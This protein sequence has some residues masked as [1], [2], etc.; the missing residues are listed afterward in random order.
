MPIKFFLTLTLSLCL[1]SMV[2]AQKTSIRGA[3]HLSPSGKL[4]TVF[5]RFG[6]KYA[7]GQIAIDDGLRKTTTAEEPSATIPSSC[8]S[9]YFRMYLETGCGFDGADPASVARLHVLCQVL[10]DL[11]QLINSPCTA[12]GQKINIWVKNISSMGGPSGALGVA[13]SFFTV[14]YSTTAS[15]IAD[16]TVWVTANSGIDAYKNVTACITSPG[17]IYG[18]GPTYYHGQMAFSCAPSI[19]WHTDLSTPPAAGEYDLYTV[20]LH[21]MMHALGFL[22]L[23]DHNGASRLG[24]GYNYFTRFD[25]HLQMPTGTPI[26]SSATAASCGMYNQGFNASLSPTAVL[27]PGSSSATC[28]LGYQTGPYVNHTVCANA[29]KYVGST[30]QPVYTP[31]CYEPGSSLCHFEDECSVPAGYVLTPPASNDQYF[32]MCNQ[33]ALGPYNAATNPGAMKRYPRPEERSVLCD[34]GYQVNATYGNAAN[35]NSYSYGGSACGSGMAIGINDGI[36]STGGFAFTAILTGMPIDINAGTSGGSLLSNDYGVSGGSFKCLEVV[37]GSGTFT[38]TTGTATT[39]VQYTPGP[40]SSGLNLLRY[41]PVSATGVEGNITYVY[42][43]VPDV[44]CT[45]TTCDYA[46]NGS[47]EGV[48]GDACGDVY[49]VMSC[50]TPFVNS[51]DLMKRGATA[52]PACGWAYE[53][54]N[55]YYS[56]PADDVHPLSILPNDH[57]A[58]MY[59]YPPSGSGAA[60]VEG[61]QSG[62]PAPLLPG[63]YQISF[64]ARMANGTGYTPVPSTVEFGLSPS[65]TP[66]STYFTL[67]SLP[68]GIASLAQIPVTVPTHWHY[69]SK[70]VTYSGPPANR[71]VVVHASYLNPSSLGSY[72]G[73]MFID[74]VSIK[75]I[76]SMCAFILP[77]TICLSG[78]PINLNPTVSV[79]GGT[80]SWMKD[81]IGF[82]VTSHDTLMD[83]ASAYSASAIL[84]DTGN[85]TVCYTYSDAVG[86]VQTVC[87]QAH[88]L[89]ISVPPITGTTGICI[90]A[91]T[92]LADATTGGS[93]STGYASVVSVGSATGIVTGLA[94]GTATVT[95]KAPSGCWTTT[96]ISVDP[97]PIMGI[98]TATIGSTITLSSSTAGGTWSSSTPAVATIGSATGVVTAIA[99]GTTTISYTTTCGTVT[100]VVTVT[101]VAGITSAATGTASVSVYPN[102]SKGILL[103][104]ATMLGTATK[105]VA[106][107]FTDLEGK[108]L[109]KDMAMISRGQLKKNITLGDQF[110]NGIYLI[111]LKNEEMNSV[112]R[113]VLQR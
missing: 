82:A 93:W 27:S 63:T 81:T 28:P 103:V 111:R 101:E 86:C 57:W 59:G 39:L 79:P 37:L 43:F 113:F 9:G 112:V 97:Y 38:T 66:L 22:S 13:S 74:D 10:N 90:G 3:E 16:N 35:L 85:V 45:P 12:T 41:I 69:Y 84:H 54:P 11:S 48:G 23:V 105:Q 1:T 109:L 21:E 70:T 29:I 87:T 107:E 7:L 20:A 6:N 42:V 91:T 17:G 5:D 15:G 4:D 92:T 49:G 55:T 30:T 75:P 32:V 98:T 102:P 95:Y 100:T 65:T 2:F 8:S 60:T 110:A 19:H 64:W 53:I 24:N 96:V 50:W 61:I 36:T 56:S 40:G 62:L 51:P 67:G 76:S 89:L 34:I 80:F 46:M 94:A 18:S 108:V 99:V 58:G 78:G 33:G 72:M 77:D 31:S 88:I 14:P 104:S 68:A 47:F 26:L 71:L 25:T 83:P 73:Y 52:T 44:N 106:I